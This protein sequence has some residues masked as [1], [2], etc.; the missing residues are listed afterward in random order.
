MLEAEFLYYYTKIY[1]LPIVGA[2]LM[3]ENWTDRDF[4]VKYARYMQ[5]YITI[6]D[7]LYNPDK[8]DNKIM[9]ALAMLRENRLKSMYKA[10]FEFVIT[11]LEKSKGTF[12]PEKKS[13]LENRLKKYISLDD[14]NFDYMRE[15]RKIEEEEYY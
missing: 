14:V 12:S 6:K 2:V 13:S 3:V 10:L 5:E 4:D 7:S 1:H 15:I 9:A 8:P 11:K